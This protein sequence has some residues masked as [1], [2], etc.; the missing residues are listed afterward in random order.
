[1]GGKNGPECRINC[2]ATINEMNGVQGH[3]F[4]LQ[5]Y[6]GPGTTWDNEMN[7]V[8]NHAPGAGWIDCSTC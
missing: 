6:T 7:F 3:N 1:M 5:G 2:I 4:A 8:M